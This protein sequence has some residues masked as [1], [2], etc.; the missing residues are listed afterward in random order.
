MSRK[1]IILI[2]GIFSF[3]LYL[4]TLRGFIGNVD[5]FDQIK[6]IRAHGTAFESPH[7]RSSY[8]LTLAIRDNQTVALDRKTA[9]WGGN[10]VGTYQGKI[11]SFFPPG[12]PLIAQPLLFI[13]G[14]VGLAQAMSY[15][16]VTILACGSIV[17]LALICRNIFKLSLP[18]SILVGLL[19]AFATPSWSYA[20]TFYQHHATAFLMLASF[21]SA[22]LFTQNHKL[23][24]LSISLGLY[25]LSWIFDYTNLVILFPTVGFLLWHIWKAPVLKRRQLF[26]WPIVAL[27]F[28]ASS[29]MIYNTAVFGSWSI[30]S[31]NLPRYNASQ[32]TKIIET[33]QRDSAV[34]VFSPLHI[35]YG[36]Y[37]FLFMPYRG[38]LWF[39]PL[40]IV[41]L[42]SAW[43]WIKKK[44]NFGIL[45][46]CL[47]G[48]TLLFYALF[49]HPEGG[50][51]FGPRFMIPLMAVLAP[52]IG[53]WL[54]KSLWRMKYTVTFI[55]TVYASAIALLGAL[56]TNMIPAMTKANE[57]FGDYTF[58]KHLTF[59]FK[60]RSP[61][62]FYN[63]F[64]AFIPLR[65]YYVILLAIVIASFLY[66]IKYISNQSTKHEH[67]I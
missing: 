8:L 51:A 38:L 50:W 1:H 22:F 36:V 21:Y 64:F 23:R 16:T 46:L 24:W 45:L 61:S 49:K 60:N 19:F 28:A 25:A 44:N 3:I 41:A 7:E 42:Y 6:N 40:Y 67:R 27:V 52:A 43:Q 11:Y 53:Y 66:I 55:L 63:E 59:L 33:S 35:P 54:E 13:G 39:S 10:D 15:A 20:I 31:N 14:L 62:L 37:T 30:T 32:P 65:L 29:V 48:T 34:K 2:V 4:A 58:H 12:L 5:T 56:T 9:Y 57:N 47:G 17:L 18:I 26:V